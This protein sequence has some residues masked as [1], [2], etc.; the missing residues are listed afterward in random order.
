MMV[1]FR[2]FV[3]PPEMIA[4]ERQRKAN[5]NERTKQSSANDSA[6]TIPVANLASLVDLVAD[7]LHC[8]AG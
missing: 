8:L 1:A 2:G 5:S 3:H 7:P 4:T 6:E